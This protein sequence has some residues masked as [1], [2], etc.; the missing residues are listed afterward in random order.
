MYVVLVDQGRCVAKTLLGNPS[1]TC[2]P[3]L[4]NVM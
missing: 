3:D 1:F 2:M 4:K